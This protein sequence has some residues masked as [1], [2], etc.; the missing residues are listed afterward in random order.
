MIQSGSLRAGIGANVP[1]DLAAAA[2]LG[3]EMG[4]R[5]ASFDWASHPLGPLAKWPLEI[6]TVVATSLVSRFPVVLW[7]GEDLSLIYNEL[8]P[9]AR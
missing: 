9:D 8:H 4:E 5:L 6:R 1:L 7:I 2:R 3:G